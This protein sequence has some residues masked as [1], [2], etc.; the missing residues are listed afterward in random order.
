M[1]IGQVGASDVR[2][3]HCCI[4]RFGRGD[5]ACGDGLIM[6]GYRLC[7]ATDNASPRCTTGF[8]YHKCLGEVE[9]KKSTL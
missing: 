3:D 1:A 9:V 6:H 5:W 4:S 8:G 2:L 7:F